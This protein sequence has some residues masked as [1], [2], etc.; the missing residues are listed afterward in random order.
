M[1]GTAGLP[2]GPG[3]RGIL[4]AA[5]VWQDLRVLLVLPTWRDS[6]T[7]PLTAVHLEPGR[8]GG[9]WGHEAGSDVRRM[10]NCCG[11]LIKPAGGGVDT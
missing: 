1:P 7:R 4:P 10:C 8:G 9:A 5:G 6:E 2:K 11:L 3:R